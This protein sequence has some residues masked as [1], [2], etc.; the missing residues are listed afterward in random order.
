MS[1]IRRSPSRTYFPPFLPISARSAR[2]AA[3]AD[4]AAA[5]AAWRSSALAAAAR[6]LD[7]RSASDVTEM[8]EGTLPVGVPAEGGVLAVVF[9]P[10]MRDVGNPPALG[11]PLRNPRAVRLPGV[12]RWATASRGGRGVPDAAPAALFLGVG[13][14]LPLARRA[15]IRASKNVARCM[16]MPP[17][18]VVLSVPVGVDGSTD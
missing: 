6:L 18:G 4:R 2:R 17:V 8:E 16:T 12:V 9:P 10:A 7:A 3:A 5:V 14:A 15:V 11:V 1:T 13:M